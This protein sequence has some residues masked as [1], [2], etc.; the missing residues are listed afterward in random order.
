MHVYNS[1]QEYV[2]LNGGELGYWKGVCRHL[3]QLAL[4]EAGNGVWKR[5]HHART[6]AMRA[7]DTACRAY[8]LS[9][10]SLPQTRLLHLLRIDILAGG[11]L[12]LTGTRRQ[13]RFQSQ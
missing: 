6:E 4:A 8:I 1:L 13:D 2:G 3:R 7:A 11:R 5:Q 10:S 12:S 9:I